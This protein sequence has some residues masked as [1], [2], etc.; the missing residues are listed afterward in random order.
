MQVIS[1]QYQHG[2]TAIIL[3]HSL[4]HPCS[5]GLN[6]VKAKFNQERYENIK[7]GRSFSNM[8]DNFMNCNWYCHSVNG[9]NC[10]HP[11]TLHLTC[12]HTHLPDYKTCLSGRT[13]MFIVCC[14]TWRSCAPHD[15]HVISCTKCAVSGLWERPPSAQEVRSRINAILSVFHSQ[16]VSML[17]QMQNIINCLYNARA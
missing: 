4:R 5:T 7:K 16:V 1:I 9:H 10:T 17:K 11:F 14:L 3:C 15:K 12:Y 6:P 13:L 2:A 8:K